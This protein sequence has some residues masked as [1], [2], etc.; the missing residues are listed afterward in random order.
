MHPVP[1]Q[2][3]VTF[4]YGKRY[5]NGNLHKGD[6]FAAR[7]GSKVVAAVSGTV[8]HVGRHLDGGWTHRGWG[9]AYGIH[10]IVKCDAFPDGSAGYFA[11]YCHLSATSVTRGQRVKKG[12][13]LGK[14]GS[15]GN[16]TGP[17]LHFE[18]QKRR[19]WGGWLGSVNPR[20]WRQA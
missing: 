10:V 9:K 1:V 8:V 14:V 11:G 13:T 6:D 3:T 16:S 2:P 7:T 4:A 15:T 18:I 5:S 17:H 12:Q 19:Y 20:K